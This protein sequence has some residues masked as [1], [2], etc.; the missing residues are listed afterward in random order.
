MDL[1]KAERASEAWTRLLKAASE[2]QRLHVEAGMELPAP[3]R[4]MLGMTSTVVS[5]PP[6]ATPPVKRPAKSSAKTG[7]SFVPSQL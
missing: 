4:Q 7:V 6:P 1:E 3:L 2:C 5:I